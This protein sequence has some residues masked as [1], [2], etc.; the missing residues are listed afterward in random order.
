MMLWVMIIVVVVASLLGDAY[1]RHLKF[2]ER[3]LKIESSMLEKQL[4]LEQVKHETFKLETEKLRLDL[5]K[6]VQNAPSK[7][8][9]L[10]YKVKEKN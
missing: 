8:E 5:Q 2:R 4:Q 1:H 9:L 6:D 3:K 7:D 10:E